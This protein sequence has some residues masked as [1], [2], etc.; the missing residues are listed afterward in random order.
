MKSQKVKNI[1]YLCKSEF[2]LSGE[3]KEVVI[4]PNGAEVVSLNLEIPTAIVGGSV[5]I[6][7]DDDDSFFL[8]AISTAKAECHQSAKLTTITKSSAITAKAT[9][10]TADDAKAIIRVMYYL[11]SEILVEY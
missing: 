11:P 7:L 3:S 2:K 10:I 8:N 5:S 9:G 4:V 1:S 6:G